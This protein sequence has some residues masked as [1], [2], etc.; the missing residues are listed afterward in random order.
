MKTVLV[1]GA[2]GHLGQKVLPLLMHSANV[3]A[4]S[5]RNGPG[6]QN[7]VW[8]QGDLRDSGTLQNALDGVDTVLHLATSPLKV[9][10][11]LQMTRTLLNASRD[12]Q[13]FVYMSIVGLED[14]PGAP[15]YREKRAIEELIKIS[16]LPHSIVRATQF[17]EF[18]VELLRMLTRGPVTL[19]PTGASV[20]PVAAQAVAERLAQIALGEP[21]GRAP[22]IG[23]PQALTFA[24]MARTWQAQQNLRKTVLSVPLPIPIFKAWRNGAALPKKAEALGPTWAEWLQ[25]TGAPSK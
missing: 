24:D 13:H 5:R 23:G 10:E 3:R 11:D 4:I 14:M 18:M 19:A 6:E 22:D 17:H 21:V 12:V 16:G 2:T 25:A 8:L 9:G 1:T 20:Q 15:Y 7:L